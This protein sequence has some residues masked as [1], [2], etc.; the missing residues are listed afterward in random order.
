MTK[1]STWFILGGLLLALAG[2][3]AIIQAVADEG[4]TR[5]VVPWIR[6]T[7]IVGC[8]IVAGVVAAL[9]PARRAARLDIL[10][11]VASE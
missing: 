8:A 4:I 11:A 5:V 2:S 6:I 3:W 7:V 10:R 9:G 1:R